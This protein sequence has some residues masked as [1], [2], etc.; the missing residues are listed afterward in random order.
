MRRALPVLL[1]VVM[2]AACS[3][4]RVQSGG[5]VAGLSATLSVERFMGAA[6]SR[7]FVTMASIFGTHDG[8]ISDTGSTFGCFWKKLGSIFGG[9]SCQNWRDVE[10][11]MELISQV[12]LHDDYQIRSER[13]VAGVRHPTIR[14][15]VDVVQRQIRIRDVGFTLVQTNDGRWMLEQI[16]LERLTRN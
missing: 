1:F 13:S 12:M 15:S 5:A 14:L 9:S 11:R 7:D 3:T 10:L 8:P 4:S 2:A 16:E 6:N